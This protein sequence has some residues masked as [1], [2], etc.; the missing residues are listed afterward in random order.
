[1]FT[2]ILTFAMNISAH[3]LELKIA[4]LQN[5]EKPMSDNFI[6]VG[7]H[8]VKTEAKSVKARFHI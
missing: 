6:V 1:M 7:D 3:D 5:R 8:G 2:I 4:A